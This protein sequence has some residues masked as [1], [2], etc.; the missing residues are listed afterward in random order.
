MQWQYKLILTLLLCLSIIIPFSGCLPTDPITETI[1][2]REIYTTDNLTGLWGRVNP[3]GVGTVVEVVQTYIN[4]VSENDTASL[5]FSFEPS[6]IVIAYSAI[7]H[8]ENF[9]FEVGHTTGH[10]II[11]VTA[12]DTIT[13][14]TNYTA[15][16]DYNG[17][18]DSAILHSNTDVLMAAGGYDGVT[19][20]RCWGIGTWT[21]ATHTLLIEFD[22]VQNSH[23]AWNFFEI[24]ATAYK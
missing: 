19:F 13:I 24:V 16:C 21:T 7:C 3:G 14:N 12:I 9:P 2:E 15:I 18:M 20:A 17:T 23:D 10:S 6:K 8:H 11:N 4:G 5:V 22:D 1:Y